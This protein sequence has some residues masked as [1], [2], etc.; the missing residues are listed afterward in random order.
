ML[1]KKKWLTRGEL[2]AL[3]VVLV[4][5]RNFIKDNGLLVRT[6]RDRIFSEFGNLQYIEGVVA[7]F[8]H[9]SCLLGMKP[10]IGCLPL[11]EKRKA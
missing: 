5:F 1:V 10:K 8:Y 2:P 6:R 9:L 7:R 4:H 11:A 3:C